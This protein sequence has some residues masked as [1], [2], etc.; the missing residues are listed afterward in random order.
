[1]TVRQNGLPGL[2]LGFL[3]EA[4]SIAL[5]SIAFLSEFAF[6][7]VGLSDCVAVLAFAV[8]RLDCIFVLQISQGFSIVNG[9]LLL[10]VRDRR[11]KALIQFLPEQSISRFMSVVR[12]GLNG[13]CKLESVMQRR[14]LSL[15]LMKSGE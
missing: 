8:R 6:K 4:F 10:C 5:K 7:S 11:N 13:N 9:G 3:P 12:R 1:M 14:G 2:S 15:A